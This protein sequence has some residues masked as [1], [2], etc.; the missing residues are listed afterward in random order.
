[1][2]GDVIDRSVFAAG[3]P[4]G[5]AGYP[6][7]RIKAVGTAPLASI[8]IIRNAEI[9]HT[10]SPGIEELAVKWSDPSPPD[11]TNWYYVR[12]IQT[13]GEIAW[14]SPIWVR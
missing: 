5:T 13:D 7:I 14:G 1:M 8:D 9:V 11:R 2:M 12:V 4:G 3:R 6:E 10:Y